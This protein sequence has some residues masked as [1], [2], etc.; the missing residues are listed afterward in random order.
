MRSVPGR[1]PPLDVC[2]PAGLARQDGYEF[3]TYWSTVLQVFLARVHV[4]DD[5]STRW[6]QL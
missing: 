3:L 1:D 4:L 5:R 6:V 2:L